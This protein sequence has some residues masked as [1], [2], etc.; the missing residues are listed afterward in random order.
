MKEFGR[1]RL[2]KFGEI[3]KDK[4]LEKKYTQQTLSE[5]VGIDIRTIQRIESGTLNLSINIFIELVL[6]LELD[7]QEI[8]KEL[9]K[10]NPG[11]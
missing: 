8:I 4:R 5:L 7:A 3:I 11:E 9:S 1:L 6:N 2:I 10:V